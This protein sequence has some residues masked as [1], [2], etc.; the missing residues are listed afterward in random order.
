[1]SP[2]RRMPRETA[3]IFLAVWV[4]S[5]ILY[6]YWMPPDA[7]RAVAASLYGLVFGLGLVLLRLLSADLEAPAQDWRLI[8]LP[9]DPVLW[10]LVALSVAI[11]LYPLTLPAHL[12]GAGDE[13]V[14]MG[15]PALPFKLWSRVC[16]IPFPLVFWA[17]LIFAWLSRNRWNRSLQGYILAGAHGRPIAIGA[18]VIGA[19]AYF[20]L[21]FTVIRRYSRSGYPTLIP[22]LLRTPP[23]AKAIHA[24]FYAAFGVSDFSGRLPELLFYCAA[25]VLIYEI[26]LEWHSKTAARLAALLYLFLPP[27]AYY[28]MRGSQ[29]HG[30]LFFYVLTAYFFGR[31]LKDRNAAWMYWATVSASAGTLYRYTVIP[32]LAVLGL[33]ALREWRRDMIKD[34]GR[35]LLLASAAALPWALSYLFLGLRPYGAGS[36]GYLE[37]LLEPALSIVAGN[38]WPMA[39]LLAAGVICA[40]TRRKDSFQRFLLIWFAAYYLFISADL[41]WDVRLTLPFYAPMI[42]WTAG[43]LSAFDGAAGAAGGAVLA[44]LLWIG[45]WSPVWP[46]KPEYTLR[47]S[48]ETEYVPLKGAADV[49]S[50]LPERT[51]LLTVDCSRGCFS[52][53]LARPDRLNWSVVDSTKLRTL[54]DL[55]RRCRQERID[56]VLYAAGTIEAFGLRKNPELLKAFVSDDVRFSWRADLKLGGNR[57]AIKDLVAQQ[58]SK[59]SIQSSKSAS[60][61]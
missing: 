17:V 19:A 14:H 60:S 39:A 41:G 23:L 42:L 49:L 43:L 31:W 16:P 29:T 35:C 7:S 18:L 34:A 38:S 10:S 32:M 48:L 58:P 45:L 30:E 8:R 3:W 6:P 55:V 47:H 33:M 9:R 36:H 56:T 1:M 53:Y 50:T 2:A 27:L 51:R 13:A 11:R 22:D 28:A 61:L 44:F 37:G 12:W 46:L 26:A 15:L 54:D 5:H 59:R 25:A 24:L 20:E 4:Y 21:A 40:L 57:I 52:F